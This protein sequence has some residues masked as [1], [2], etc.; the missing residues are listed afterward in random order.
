MKGAVH[1]EENLSSG[2]KEAREWKGVGNKRLS[3]VTEGYQGPN[4]VTP[5]ETEV[6][7]DYNWFCPLSRRKTLMSVHSHQNID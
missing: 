4:L 6:L 3:A 2:A 1:Q 5:A 7:P